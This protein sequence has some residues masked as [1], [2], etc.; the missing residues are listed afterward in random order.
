MKDMAYKLEELPIEYEYRKKEREMRKRNHLCIQCGQQDAYTL[1]GR[2]RCSRCCEQEKPREHE[3]YKKNGKE[4]NRRRYEKY[5][6][7]GH[8]VRC[9]GRS[10][11]EERFVKPVALNFHRIE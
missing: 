10:K 11:A 3:N 9:G 8:C 2:S 1:A 7:E 6:R 4:S 5:L